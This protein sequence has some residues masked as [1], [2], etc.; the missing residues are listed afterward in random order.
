MYFFLFSHRLPLYDYTLFVTFLKTGAR[1]EG[2]CG[3]EAGTGGAS[4]HN[5]IY[6]Y[7]IIYFNNKKAEDVCIIM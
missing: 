7:I 5:I 6:I 3:E 4:M 1:G 2:E